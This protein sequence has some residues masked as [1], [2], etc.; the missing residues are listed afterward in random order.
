MKK[1][2]KTASDKEQK[3]N[4]PAFVKRIGNVK[5]TVFENEAESGRV[6]SNISVVR[7]YRASDGEFHDTAVL[8]GSGDAL[9]AI[10]GMRCCIDFVNKRE[11]GRN[12]SAD[13]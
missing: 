3:T 13:E 6:Y 12:E 2:E 1:G 4:S 9:A 10:E 5:C 11:A 7:R 8:N